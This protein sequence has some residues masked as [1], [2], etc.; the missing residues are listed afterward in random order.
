MDIWDVE[1]GK[2]LYFFATNIDPQEDFNM[3]FFPRI[4]TEITLKAFEEMGILD[5]K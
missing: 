2:E 3:D 5:R 1:K 4:R